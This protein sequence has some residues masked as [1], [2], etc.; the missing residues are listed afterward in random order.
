MIVGQGELFG[1]ASEPSGYKTI[2][3]LFQ[4]K[5]LKG[6]LFSHESFQLQPIL[7]GSPGHAASCAVLDQCQ[8][9]MAPV[10]FGPATV[11]WVVKPTLVVKS[12]YCVAKLDVGFTESIPLFGFNGIT[13]PIPTWSIIAESGWFV[14]FVGVTCRGLDSRG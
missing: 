10:F 11:R 9:F 4:L 2:E 14:D 13:R 1:N 5:E 7:F 3:A 6:E 12:Q 8:R